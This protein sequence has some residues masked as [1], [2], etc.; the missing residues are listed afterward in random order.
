MEYLSNTL[1]LYEVVAG[2]IGPRSHVGLDAR[3]GGKKFE[4]F[5]NLQ[6][7]EFLRGLYNRQRALEALAI[8]YARSGGVVHSFNPPRLN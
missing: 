3:I 6:L 5:P 1:D 8:E 2:P 4:D 7:L